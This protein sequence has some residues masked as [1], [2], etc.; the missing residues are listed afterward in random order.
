PNG[1]IMEALNRNGMAWKDYYTNL[2]SV[3]LYLPVLS[4]NR[5]KVVKIDEFF[6]DVAAGTL[7]AF[8]MVEPDY[9]H[10]SEENP[11]D[12]S[13]GEAF[14]ATV[15][16]A[17]MNGPAW[18]KTLLVWLY[19][20]HG[21]YYDHVPPPP[22][23]PPDDVLPHLIPGDAPG[24]YARYGFRVPAVVVSPWAKRDYVSSVVHDH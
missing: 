15:V 20:E 19:D 18:P 11:E 7:P 2:P 4:A 1:T 16:N 12:V 5:D 24:D 8:C 17:V 3:G 9:A 22:A 13:V 6:T 21:G 14:V 23:V 10:A